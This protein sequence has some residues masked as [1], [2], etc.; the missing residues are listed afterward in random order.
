MMNLSSAHIWL[1]KVGNKCL[2]YAAL[3]R[4]NRP[5][6]ILLLLW[7]TLWALWVAGKG[8]PEPSLILI[9]I[10]GVVLMRSAGCVINDLA[11]RKYDAEVFRT[12]QRP[13]VTKLVSP[14]EALLLFLML[15]LL[16]ARLLW[17]L[18][19]LTKWLAIPAILI[20]VSYPFMKRYTHLPQLILGIAFSWGV[21]MAFA[22]QT[23]K[24]N[25]VGW[26]M[27]A[28]SCIWPICYDTMYAMVDR[29]DDRR[30]GI[31][32]TAILF[33][34]WDIKIIALLHLTMLLLLFL[35]GFELS[36]GLPF[37]IS[38]LFAA[39]IMG[40]QHYLIKDR[41]PQRCFQAF[42]TSQWVGCALFIGL[43]FCNYTAP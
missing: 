39:G 20:A 9:F 41:T 40:Y 37:Y 26:C 23:G 16:A 42:L 22:A 15:A 8:S 32:S 18:N 2:A 5:I 7:P 4:L 17:P 25:D 1:R 28:I 10:S 29:K 30:V 34:S 21:P 33:G 14:K 38:L 43:F 11:D 13:L 24:I 12:Q 31:K 35:L 27:F 36:W 19:T 3:M 6:G